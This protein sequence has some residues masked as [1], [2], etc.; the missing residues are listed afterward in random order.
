M[1]RSQTSVISQKSNVKRNK[2]K[3]GEQSSSVDDA[4][5]FNQGIGDSGCRNILLV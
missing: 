2:K 4:N 5:L 3:V 1:E